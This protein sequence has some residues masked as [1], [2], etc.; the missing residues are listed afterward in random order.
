M[1]KLTSRDFKRF[2]LEAIS[3]YTSDNE[4]PVTKAYKEYN[5]SVY[6]AKK[7]ILEASKLLARLTLNDKARSKKYAP[8]QKKFDE[9]LK[10]LQDASKESE[11][12]YKQ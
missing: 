12:I 3:L 4:S 6:S 11:Y 5:D 2:I 8:V 10:I 7:G 1:K 9:I